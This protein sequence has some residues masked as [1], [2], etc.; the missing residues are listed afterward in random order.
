[1]EKINALSGFPVHLFANKIS[2]LL[3]L[4]LAIASSL[5]QTSKSNILVLSPY[6]MPSH[7][8]FIRP[9]VKELASRGH[10]V[11]FWNGLE[12]TIKDLSLNNN[13]RQLY[14]PSLGELNSDQ[15]VSFATRHQQFSLLLSMYDR[16]VSICKTIYEENIFY[17]LM[18]TDEQFDLVIVEGFLNECVLPLVHKFEAP[19]IYLTGIAP[20]PWILDAIGSPLASDHFPYPGFNFTDPTSFWQRSLNTLSGIVGICFRNWLLMPTVDTL[21]ARMLTNVSLPSART[22]EKESLSLL[23]TNTHF[24]I[25]H[26]LPTTSNVIEVGGLHCVPSQPLPKVYTNK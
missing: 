1:M 16:T 15:K 2:I 13:L 8:N 19:L 6:T 24:S 12:P 23:I 9:V 3:L 22:I 5:K 26:Q 18:T 17:Q 7:S 20:P 21:A 14:S 4:I 11:T 25:N 10:T